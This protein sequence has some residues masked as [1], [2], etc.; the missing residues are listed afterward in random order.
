MTALPF[1]SPVAANGAAGLLAA[2]GIG[3][4][5]GWSLE[6]AGLG[7]ARKLAAQFY[8]TDLAVFRV[9]FTAIVTAALGVFWLSWL[10]VLDLAKVYVPPTFLL[11]QAVGGIVFGAG[12]VAGGLCPGTGCVAAATGRKDG[13]AVVA[14]M[15]AGVFVFSEAFPLVRGFYESTPRGALTFPALLNLPYGVVLF[16]LVALALGG[17]AGADRVE[18][19]ARRLAAGGG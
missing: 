8:L 7:S 10:G 17:F 16:A 12:M 18:R 15:L 3:V 11:P 2:L 19:R 4:A 5:F 13:A 14:G 6:R 9:M 1:F